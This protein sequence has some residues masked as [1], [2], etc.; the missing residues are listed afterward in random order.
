MT[1]RTRLTPSIALAAALAAAAAC[2]DSPSQPAGP[3]QADACTRLGVPGTFAGAVSLDRGEAMKLA[4]GT[5]L[6]LA[7]PGDAGNSYALAYVDTRP[8]QAARTAPEPN[9]ADSFRVTV[10]A[11]GSTRA[12]RLAAVPAPR[13]PSDLREVTRRAS[14]QSPDPTFRA[15]PWAVGDT[16]H[17]LQGNDDA[18][19]AVSVRRVYD[20]W[21]VIAARTDTVEASV[22]GMLQVLDEA[23]PSIRDTGLPLLRKTLGDRLPVTSTGSGQLLIVVRSDIVGA[24]GI[25]FGATDAANV[26][27]HIAVLP[28]SGEDYV[29]AV[30]SLIV[31]EIAHTFQRQYIADSRPAGTAPTRAAGGT[32]WAVE[33]GATLMQFELARRLAGVSWGSNWDFRAPAGTGQAFYGELGPVSRGAFSG[34]Y[35]N[36]ASFL[37]DLAE[38][39]VRKGENVDAALAQVM[40]GAVEGW[41]GHVLWGPDLPGLASRMRGVLGNGWEPEDALF[42]WTLSH[43]ADDRTPSGTFQD[44][45]F[46][47]VWDSGQPGTWSAIATLAPGSQPV[48]V[49]QDRESTGFFELAGGGTYSLNATRDGVRWMIVRLQ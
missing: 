33:G 43:A 22:P 3:Q 13:M 20:G 6:C 1:P 47:R 24:S 4:A 21:L 29:P 28:F 48:T 9:V 40:R 10:G 19:R 46:L 39:R 38:R 37:R 15:T 16:F 30:G 32:A 8:L 11:A 41:F 12:A 18:A 31:H 36:P 42:T 35:A 49:A 17:V 44:P 27:S 34:G 7:L 26:F 25:A 5:Q 45:A 14:A 2:S 23:W